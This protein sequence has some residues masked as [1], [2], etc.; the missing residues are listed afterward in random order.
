MKDKSNSYKFMC[1]LLINSYQASINYTWTPSLSTPSA[2]PLWEAQRSVWGCRGQTA[3][4]HYSGSGLQ[5]H[6]QAAWR[7]DET[8]V[9]DYSQTDGTVRDNSRTTL[10]DL[11]KDLKAAGT[12]HCDGLKPCSTQRYSCWRAHVHVKFVNEHMNDSDETWENLMG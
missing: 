4:L 5:E 9:W 1:I 12:L 7:E 8:C 3:D 2:S 10:E 6:Q 11:M